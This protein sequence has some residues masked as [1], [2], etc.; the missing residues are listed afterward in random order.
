[1]GGER[2]GRENGRKMVRKGWSEGGRMGE[3]GRVGVR[4]VGGRMGGR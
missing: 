2:G 4:V 1:M 3:G